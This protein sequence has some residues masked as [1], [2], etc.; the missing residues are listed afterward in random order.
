MGVVPAIDILGRSARLAAQAFPWRQPLEPNR[1]LANSGR[2]LGQEVG[3]VVLGPAHQRHRQPGQQAAHAAGLRPVSEIAGQHH[4][5]GL[6][7][8]PGVA[9][10][11]PESP[12][13]PF[14]RIR[15]QGLADTGG[16]PEAR[17]A[18]RARHGGAGPHQPADDGR[19]RV[20]DVDRLV[21]EDGEA[22]RRGG[23]RLVEQDGGAGRQRGDEAESGM[24]HPAGFAGR[25]DQVAGGEAQGLRRA[26]DQPAF[27]TTVMQDGARLAAGVGLRRCS[28][29]GEMD[30]AA[31]GRVGC[32][33]IARPLALETGLDLV[34]RPQTGGEDA[35]FPQGR[36]RVGYGVGTGQQQLYF[37]DVEAGLQKIGAEI[38]EQRAIDA[39]DF[40][41]R[42]GGDHRL[43]L[44]SQHHADRLAGAVSFGQQM[45]GQPVAQPREVAIGEFPLAAIAA[46]PTQCQPFGLAS[47]D[48]TIGQISET[49]YS[50]PQDDERAAL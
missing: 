24:H 29:A 37:G 10:R 40:P 34:E 33:R 13:A 35:L 17:P 30:Q 12:L 22:A 26:V 42:Q 2:A 39:A 23:R 14:D 20:P 16:D 31:L 5:A 28:A 50:T 36:H 15:R 48:M 18:D 44:A 43:R 41:H 9:E 47:P 11:R 1:H 38:G 8:P 19:R 46:T 27:E 3:L 7:L 21:L 4:A 6:G 25:P 45:A 49:Q 32:V